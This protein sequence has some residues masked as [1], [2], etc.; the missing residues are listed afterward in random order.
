MDVV[1]NTYSVTYAGCVTVKNRGT[2]H[3][4]GAQSADHIGRSNGEPAKLT[5]YRLGDS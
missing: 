1:G 5:V 2:C 4:F 3:A